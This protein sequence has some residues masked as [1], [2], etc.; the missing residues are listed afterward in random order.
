GAAHG[1]Q[2]ILSEATRTL[3]D[4][5]LPS[6]VRIRDLG[7]HRLKDLDHPEHLF[8]L[9]VEGLETDFPPPRTLDARPTNLPV[10]L[11][12]F[13]G[14]EGEIAEA[15]RLLGGTRLL[16]LTG[17]GGTGKTRL[18]LRVAS[19]VLTEF[20]DGSFF[21]DLS[22]VADPDLVPSALARALGVPEVAGRSILQGVKDDLRD[23]EL[24]LV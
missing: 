1:G 21:V 19:E 14:R 5:S 2:A 6:G 17:A 8:D 24:L 7:R 9:V 13:V 11:T 4:R 23:K 20:E 3:V 22:S 18:A 10:Q 12:S 15:R 16:T